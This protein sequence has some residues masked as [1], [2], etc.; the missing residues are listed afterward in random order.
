MLAET[1]KRREKLAAMVL[2]LQGNRARLFGLTNWFV[3]LSL[4]AA[5]CPRRH[6]TWSPLVLTSD[7][8]R[9]PKDSRFQNLSV[10]DGW[11]KRSTIW[12]TQQWV[13]R[14]R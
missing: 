14:G 6:G 7:I 11:S 5:A 13:G 3:C 8:P 2:E 1:P 4:P 9:R 10:I 12:A